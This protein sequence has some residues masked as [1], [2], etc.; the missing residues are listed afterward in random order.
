MSARRDRSSTPSRH[1]T[2]LKRTPSAIAV[3]TAVG[4]SSSPRGDSGTRRQAPKMAGENRQQFMLTSRSFRLDWSFRL[5]ADAMGSW[6]EA[7][8]TNAGDRREASG[9]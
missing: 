7:E 3:F 5:E 9:P 1:R 4:S 2:T 8:P 6:V